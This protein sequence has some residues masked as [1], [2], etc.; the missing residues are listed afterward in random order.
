MATA[1]ATSHSSQRPSREPRALTRRLVPIPLHALP[2]R[3]AWLTVA[4]LR[5]R[6]L[7]PVVQWANENLLAWLDRA[8]GGHATSGLAERFVEAEHDA[9]WQGFVD[10]A[11]SDLGLRGRAIVADTPAAFSVRIHDRTLDV[12]ARRLTKLVFDHHGPFGAL[13]KPKVNSAKLIIQE[14]RRIASTDAPKPMRTRELA[15]ALGPVATDNLG[16]GAWCVWLVRHAVRL[17][18]DGALLA[19]IERLQE[20]EDFDFFAGPTKF[21]QWGYPADLVQQQYAVLAKYDEVLTR[22]LNQHGRVA[23]ADRFDVLP[24]PAQLELMGEVQRHLDAVVLGLGSP[25]DARSAAETFERGLEHVR[26]LTMS[27]IHDQRRRGVV[28]HARERLGESPAVQA[29]PHLVVVNDNEL[30]D[31]LDAGVFQN[32]GGGADGITAFDLEQQPSQGSASIRLMRSGPPHRPLVS[33]TLPGMGFIPAGLRKRM[34]VDLARELGRADDAKL[35]RDLVTS[36]DELAKVPPPERASTPKTPAMTRSLEVLIDRGKLKRD[37]GP[38]ALAMVL[39]PPMAPVARYAA[40]RLAE[41]HLDNL[42][43]AVGD[44][45]VENA[46]HADT[47]AGQSVLHGLLVGARVARHVPRLRERVRAMLDEVSA[48]LMA[49]TSAADLA[50]LERDGEIQ[51]LLTALAALGYVAKSAGPR[52]LRGTL[53]PIGTRGDVFAFVFPPAGL[54]LEPDELVALLAL[55][56]HGVEPK[57]RARKSAGPRG[58]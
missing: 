50:A 4:E 25:V 14:I 40:P 18:E 16:D 21:R 32:W 36:G 12:P 11:F 28:R 51:A 27:N 30:V 31:A 47:Y 53:A 19:R 15:H 33:F 42:G 20:L 43:R 55:V 38:A 58:A 10:L 57:R 7:D 41:A 34:A 13:V 54:A 1:P 5:G 24:P 37:D 23:R 9:R 6:F 52:E 56:V 26:Q 49:A 45:L 17:A 48:K 46:A 3:G 8:L 44:W 35:V 29:L 39:C 22:Y 2:A